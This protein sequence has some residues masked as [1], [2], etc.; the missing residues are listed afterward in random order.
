MVDIT[1]HIEH[2]LVSLLGYNIKIFP[3][4]DSILV[5][6]YLYHDPGSVPLRLRAT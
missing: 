3:G 2:V 5:A 4:T 1:I 6:I